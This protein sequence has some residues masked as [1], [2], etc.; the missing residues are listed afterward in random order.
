VTVS[1]TEPSAR[2]RSETEWPLLRASILAF[3]NE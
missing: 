2:A 3:S 1:L